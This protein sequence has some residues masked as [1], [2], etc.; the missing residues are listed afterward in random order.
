MEGTQPKRKMDMAKGMFMTLNYVCRW[1]T[2]AT[3]A[4][5]FLLCFSTIA[6]GKS[7][8]YHRRAVKHESKGYSE[9]M[10][11]LRMKGVEGRYKK[12]IVIARKRSKGRS[13]QNK[14]PMGGKWRDYE[15]LSPE[16]K[17]RMKR[18]FREWKTLPPEKQDLLRH[19]MKRWK[20]LP[21]EERSRY[22][23]R[24]RQW[25]SLSPEEQERIRQRLKK[26][27]GLPQ[28]EKEK[29]RRRFRK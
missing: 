14:E 27:N 26:W 7:K 15:S 12:K 2:L 8:G 28:E 18:K 13:S 6:W 21:P 23:Q 16:E 4:L 22:K 9:E 24:F 5:A 17:A 29:I 10:L 1:S 20:E 25:Q 11:S 19:R 3:L